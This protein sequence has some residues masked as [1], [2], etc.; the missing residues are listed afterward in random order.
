MKL[1]QLIVIIMGNIRNHWKYCA[2]FEGL[3][4]KS[5]SFLINQATTIN[6]KPIVIGFGL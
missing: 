6:Q 2:R 5:R 4:P 1:G 3:V